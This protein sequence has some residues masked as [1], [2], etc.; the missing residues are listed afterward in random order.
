MYYMP[1]TTEFL[2]VV[3]CKQQSQ[4]FLLKRRFIEIR[5][6]ALLSLFINRSFFYC[7]HLNRPEVH[8]LRQ[9]FT[10]FDRINTSHKEFKIVHYILYF[11]V[12]LK[13]E[14]LLMILLIH[15]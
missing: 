13:F 2:F 12:L 14:I 7:I 15:Y 4:Y 5:F 11:L 3:I 8:L 10:L 1:Q 9:N 6:K